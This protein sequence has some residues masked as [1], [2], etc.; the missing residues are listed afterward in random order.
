MTGGRVV[1][2]GHTGRNFA[3]GMS[4]GVA[5]VFDPDDQLLSNINL[6]MVEL[7]PVEQAVD[8]EELRDLRV[9]PREP[10]RFRRGQKN[11]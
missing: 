3:A 9:Q 1:I 7:G 8:M 6:E 10:D 4:G 5:Y 2:L 11:T